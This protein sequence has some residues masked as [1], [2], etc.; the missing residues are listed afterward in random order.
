MS[1]GSTSSAPGP[2]S[3]LQHEVTDKFAALNPSD[4]SEWLLDR[5][6]EVVRLAC[7]RHAR[8]LAVDMNKIHHKTELLQ[9]KEMLDYAKSL[10][11]IEAVSRDVKTR[12][13]AENNTTTA[14]AVTHPEFLQ[15]MKTIVYATCISFPQGQINEV[16]LL[17]CRKTVR[18]EAV[19]GWFQG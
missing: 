15:A 6:Q 5:G 3:S 16:S 19:A 1:A 8:I 9:A 7:L 10:L 17:L 11:H 12:I 13:A 2:V 4:F 14:N 18:L